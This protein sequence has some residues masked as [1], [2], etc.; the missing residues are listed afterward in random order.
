TAMRAA[1][2]GPT[3]KWLQRF[4]LPLVAGG[5]VRVA[6][7][8]GAVELARFV[9]EAE[10]LEGECARRIAEARRMVAAELLADPLEVEL[11]A[12]ELHLAVATYDLLFLSH[13]A[14]AGSWGSSERR[15]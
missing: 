9:E 6:G 12:D 11:S 7:V 4:V 15:T 2:Q 5:D 14:A 8:V 13:P 1:A 10:I 3:A